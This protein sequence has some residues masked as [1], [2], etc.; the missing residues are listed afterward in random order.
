ML[1][2]LLVEEM[3]FYRVENIENVQSF[4]FV[5][6]LPS[7]SMYS[8]DGKINYENQ[9]VT[10]KLPVLKNIIPEGTIGKCFLEIKDK[11]NKN[12]KIEYEYVEF[13]NIPNIDIIVKEDSK[14]EPKVVHKQ[15]FEVSIPNEKIVLEKGKPVSRSK[16]IFDSSN[17]S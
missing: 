15:A 3:F 2:N 7:G 9:C 10:I 6:D 16:I 4:K 1:L 5:I 17:N 8:F 12:S 13:K 11:L 14:I